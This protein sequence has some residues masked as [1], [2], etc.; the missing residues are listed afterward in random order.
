MENQISKFNLHL[1]MLFCF[2]LFLFFLYLSSSP[3]PKAKMSQSQT[4]NY[5]NYRNR[6][7]IPLYFHLVNQPLTSLP[8]DFYSTFIPELTKIYNQTNIS[9]TCFK[10]DQ[11]NVPPN[12]LYSLLHKHNSKGFFNQLPLFQNKNTP[13]NSIH[14][15]FVDFITP[16]CHGRAYHGFPFCFINLSNYGRSLSRTIAHEIGHLFGLHHPSKEESLQNTDLLMTPGKLGTRLR[17]Q[18]VETIEENA[19]QKSK[20]QNTI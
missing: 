1:L 16:S 14:V 7:Q 6:I 5:T 12:L 3:S 15:F 2:F 18:E 20:D 10:V 17:T 19:L 13:S 9:F 8:F 4:D 11:I